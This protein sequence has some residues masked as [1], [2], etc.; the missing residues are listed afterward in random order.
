MNVIFVWLNKGLWR[1]KEHPST[2]SALRS[3]L[4]A[5]AGQNKTHLTRHRQIDHPNLTI[6]PS[7]QGLLRQYVPL[8]LLWKFGDRK[9]AELWGVPMYLVTNKL[10]DVLHYGSSLA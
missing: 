10:Y 2:Q 3:S 7:S 9:I 8:S 6:A 4:S 5:A 1:I